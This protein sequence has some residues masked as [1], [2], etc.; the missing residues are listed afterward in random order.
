MVEEIHKP[1]NKEKRVRKNKQTKTE[2]KR[3]MNKERKG[4]KENTSNLMRGRMILCVDS[5]LLFPD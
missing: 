4:E 5:D 1:K 2:R 3:E